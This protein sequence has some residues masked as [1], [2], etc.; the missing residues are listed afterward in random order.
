MLLFYRTFLLL[1]LSSNG[2]PPVPNGTFGRGTSPLNKAY[3]NNA[4]LIIL[5]W[6]YRLA[7]SRT[8]PSQGENSGSN[9][10]KVTCL[11]LPKSLFCL[12]PMVIF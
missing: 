2:Y 5:P 9:P 10:D 6:P 7:W 11:P 1:A 4:L 8:S 3:G 12:K